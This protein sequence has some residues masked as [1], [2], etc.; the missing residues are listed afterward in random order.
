[1]LR[2]VLCD[3]NLTFLNG[4]DAMLNKLFIKHNITAEVCFKTNSTIKLLN[5]LKN[6]SADILFLDISLSDK[7]NGLGVAEKIR[8]FNKSIQLVFTTGHFEYVMEAYK[9]NTFDYLV[10]PISQKK[11]EETLL[12]FIEYTKN[13]CKKFIKIN[14]TTF[15]NQDDITFIQKDGMKLIFHTKTDSYNTFNSFAKIQNILSNNF[16]RCHKSYIVNISNID[17]IES[18]SN[19]IFFDKNHF[20]Y[21][22]PKYKN[23]FLEVIKCGDSSNNIDIF[24]DSQ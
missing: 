2:F 17:H 15:I 24:D 20:C 21:I 7:V 3:D 9:V 18:N 10:K 14:G 13:S 12:R 4:L 22:G 1:M 23:N 5:Y 11:L 19:T 6:N 8:Q 16:I